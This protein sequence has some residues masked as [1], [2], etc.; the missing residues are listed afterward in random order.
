MRDAGRGRISSATDLDRISVIGREE[1]AVKAAKGSPSPFWSTS[2]PASQGKEE[3]IRGF[4]V[5]G[6]K[7]LGTAIQSWLI[8]R[9]KGE[10][11]FGLATH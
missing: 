5:P 4:R 8:A 3:R 11:A 10:G 1:A 6:R 9:G 7:G 2:A